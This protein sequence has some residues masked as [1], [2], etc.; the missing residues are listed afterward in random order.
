MVV[1][2]DCS[3]SDDQKYEISNEIIQDNVRRDVGV[4]QAQRRDLISKRVPEESSHE[5]SK[6]KQYEL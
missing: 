6:N 2:T 3:G 5:E 1:A 4:L